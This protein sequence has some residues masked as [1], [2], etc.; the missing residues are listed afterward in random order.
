[1]RFADGTCVFF[2]FE[3][4]FQ[5]LIY[6]IFRVLCNVWNNETIRRMNLLL[7]S[8]FLTGRTWYER[9]SNICHLLLISSLEY[10][11]QFVINESY[12]DFFFN[13]EI[14]VRARENMC[15]H[16][17]CLSFF[18]EFDSIIVWTMAAGVTRFAKYDLI[19]GTLNI[20]FSPKMCETGHQT[21]TRAWCLIEKKCV[22]VGRF[23]YFVPTN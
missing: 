3:L 13:I 22:K 19:I 8:Y 6:I 2:Y 17:E 1:M 16:V 4:L 10:M 18:N 11:T 21:C 23:V 14:S 20:R 9:C 7:F 12:L 5:N 15:L